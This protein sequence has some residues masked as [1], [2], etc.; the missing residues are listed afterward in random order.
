MNTNIFRSMS[1]GVYVTATMD[2]DRPTGCITNSIMQIT[3]SPATIAVSVNHDNYTNSCMKASGMFSFSILSEQS[4]P[5]AHRAFRV[6][7]GKGMSINSTASTTR[8]AAGMP[9]VKD[10]CGYVVCKIIDTM[11]TATHTVFLG[12]VVEAE[13]YEGAADAM[14]YAYYHKVVKGKSP[15]NAPTYLPEEDEAEGA[16]AQKEEEKPAEE[17]K[18]G[19]WVCRSAAT[20]T[21]AM[22]FRRISNARSASREQIN[23]KKFSDPELIERNYS[24]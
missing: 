20:S 7:V 24:V 14:T 4:D 18:T 2:K 21:R 8:W 9:V 16:A 23:L 12:E 17:K 11:E 3:S 13:V 5:G 22:S 1:Y 10:S 15:K 6:P 19:R